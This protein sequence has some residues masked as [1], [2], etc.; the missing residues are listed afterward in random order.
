MGASRDCLH[1]GGGVLESRDS[2]SQDWEQSVCSG[3]VIFLDEA[4][5]DV[6]NRTVICEP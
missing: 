1:R 6:V 3:Q 4:R 5:C 2:S